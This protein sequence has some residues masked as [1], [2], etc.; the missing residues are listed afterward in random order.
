MN[1][2][3]IESHLKLVLIQWMVIMAV[4]W[5]FG[6][7][8]QRLGQPLAVGE[9]TGGLLLG[10][11]FLGAIWPTGFAGLFPAET[12]QSLQLLA[13]IGLILLLFQVGME[14]DY[15]HLLQRSR[16]V[17]AVSLLGIVAPM[18]GGLLIGPW[19]HRRF[20]PALPFFGFQLFVCIA[21]SISAL[22]IMGRILLELK[23]ERT[24]IGAMSISSAAID[25]VVGWILLAL[26]TALVTSGF[27]AKSLTLQAGGVLALFFALRELVGPWLRRRWQKSPAG[28]NG[29]GFSA[30][31][32]ALLLTVLFTCALITNLLGLFSIFGAFLLGTALHQEVGL[33]RTWREKFAD[34]VNLA[35]VPIFF[36]NTGLRTEVG[37]LGSVAAWLGCALVLLMATAGKLGGCY[38]GARLTGQTAREAGCIAA[39]MNTRALM[40]LVAINIGLELELLTRELFTMFVIM[41]LLTTVMTGPLLRWWLPPELRQGGEANRHDEGLGNR[42]LSARPAT[43][44]R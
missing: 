28:T 27:D 6:R 12:Q 10:P 44:R 17:T 15:G 32:L 36:T 31:Y 30:S 35:L 43:R 24:A 22:P 16:T 3:S 39:L 41:A 9:I 38:L 13:K 8:G 2:T 37:S 42:L 7:A 23:L 25:D 21:M 4:A 34:F 29:E 1:P 14:F 20:G 19:L 18:L 5:F 33:V 26:A 40:G 11:S